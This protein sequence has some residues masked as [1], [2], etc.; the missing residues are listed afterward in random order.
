MK[1]RTT[2]LCVWTIAVCG[3]GVAAGL[4]RR[5]S[6]SNGLAFVPLTPISA[7]A[8]DDDDTKPKP[9][10]AKRNRSVEE[11]PS[12]NKLSPEEARVLL[13]KGTE[14]PFTGE[15]T[16]TKDPGTYICRRCNAPL[17][18]AKDKFVSECGW[19]SFD[20]EIKGAVKR[21]RESD[22][23]G[24]TEIV[25]ENCGGHLGHVFL[26]EGFTAKNTRHCVN[27]ISMRFIPEGK[28]LPKMIESPAKKAK[29]AKEKAD[30]EKAD[31]DKA[32]KSKEEKPEVKKADD[33]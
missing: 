22:G 17:Y 10:N 18:A 28:E 19:P 21:R 27:S 26:G 25:C 16:T 15:Y 24:R 1:L 9:S 31:K 8:D 30:K 20:D 5:S 3:L 32:E 23:T 11:E 6:P 29:A 2:T 12:F 33:K 13:R 4:I 7:P 14:L